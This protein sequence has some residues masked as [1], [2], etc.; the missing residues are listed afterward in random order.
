MIAIIIGNAARCL[1][2]IG[3]FWLGGGL[4]VFAL[5]IWLAR[6]GVSPADV[7]WGTQDVLGRWFR[8]CGL[9]GFRLGR[10]A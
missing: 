3:A 6:C 8:W 1:A 9:L 7:T 4:T 10:R 2:V 5:G